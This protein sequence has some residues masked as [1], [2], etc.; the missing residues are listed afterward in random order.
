MRVLGFVLA[1]LAGPVA[2]QSWTSEVILDVGEMRALSHQGSVTG[3]VTMDP[4][5]EWF[6]GDAFA[7][8]VSGRVPGC[9]DISEM[10]V[11]FYAGVDADYAIRLI[12]DLTRLPGGGWAVS[13]PGLFY[14]DVDARE[15][16]EAAY[17]A[18]DGD[19][20]VT[21]SDVA[22]EG[23]GRVRMTMRFAAVL[24]RYDGDG[25]VSAQ[26]SGTINGSSV[27]RSMEEF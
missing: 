13:D 18:Y 24:E 8:P 25:P 4:Q 23:A 5:G 26:M 1:L 17:E 2:A 3:L 7:D 15:N 22:C 12:I 9:D 11:D 27:I 16:I 14:M 20:K 6:A 10:T 19:T 21:V